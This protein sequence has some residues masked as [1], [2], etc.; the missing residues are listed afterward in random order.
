MEEQG[1]EKGRDSMG[2]NN[3]IIRTSREDC[4]VK[5]K[6][7][8]VLLGFNWCSWYFSREKKF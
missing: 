2:V 7:K 4:E 8:L 6:I 5:N 3:G 1:R